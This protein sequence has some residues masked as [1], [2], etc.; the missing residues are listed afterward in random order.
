MRNQSTLQKSKSRSGL[1]LVESRPA[2]DRKRATAQPA[3]AADYYS[4]MEEYAQKIRRTGDVDDIIVVLEEALR[5]TR[6]LHSADEVA[7]AREQLIN[8]EQRIEHLKCELELVNQLVRED[9]LTGAL[10]RRGLYDALAR[11]AA[12]AERKTAPLCVALIDLDDFKRLNDS[13]GHQAGDCVLVHLVSVVRDF[14][15]SNDLIGRYGGEEFML[16]L[17][18]SRIGEAVEVIE[19]LRRGLAGKPIAWG[20]N[21]L[22]VTFSAG[23][24]E[25]RAGE[26]A[27][28]LIERADS[29]MY[30]AKRLGKNRA[31]IAQ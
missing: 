26:K 24:A 23:V 5:E 4:R 31:L 7:A 10:N 1:L 8:A 2:V 30:E 20:A 15:R 14:I 16:L 22:A 12:R 9:Q 28:S 3:A 27:H 17:P 6:A 13:F 25:R 19:R 21:S 29:A 18:D 11:E